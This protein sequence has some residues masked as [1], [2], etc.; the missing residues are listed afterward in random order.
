[1]N[2]KALKMSTVAC[3]CAGSMSTRG[4]T[5]VTKVFFQ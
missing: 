4:Y 5:V 1:M 3:A 2:V